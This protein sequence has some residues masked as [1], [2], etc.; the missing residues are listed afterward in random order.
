MNGFAGKS[1]V[2]ITYKLPDGIKGFRYVKNHH[3]VELED[4]HGQSVHLPA[5]GIMRHACLKCQFSWWTVTNQ[6][7][8]CPTCG[9]TEVVRKWG[10]LQIAFVPDKES[11]FIPAEDLLDQSTGPLGMQSVDAAMDEILDEEE[12]ALLA[13]AFDPE[14]TK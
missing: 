1:G 2:R 5:E 12:A 6:C 3:Y 11:T 13:D 7:Q 14:D 4:D 10:K 8:F 9:H